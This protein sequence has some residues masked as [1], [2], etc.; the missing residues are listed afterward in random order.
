LCREE[1][2]EED[3]EEETIE[4]LNEAMS[5]KTKRRNREKETPVSVVAH[6]YS[7]KM[8]MLFI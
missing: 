8:L 4:A 6:K 1:E 5:E 2:E 3:D 7:R